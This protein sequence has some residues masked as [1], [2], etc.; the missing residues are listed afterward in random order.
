MIA[1]DLLVVS[2]QEEWLESRR[3]LEKDWVNKLKGVQLKYQEIITETKKK[4]YPKL[5]EWLS[6]REKGNIL[7]HFLDFE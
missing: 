6:E 2:Y 5:N 7:L 1:K 3:K 4:T